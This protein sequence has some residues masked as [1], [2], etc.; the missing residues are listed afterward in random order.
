MIEKH[1]AEWVEEKL[2]LDQVNSNERR[3]KFVATMGKVIE[4]LE[5]SQSAAKDLDFED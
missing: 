4:E 5:I 2:F 3:D 1:I